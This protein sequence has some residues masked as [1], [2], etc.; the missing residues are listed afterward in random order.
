MFHMVIN[1]G[2]TSANTLE[3]LRLLPMY[4]SRGL[5]AQVLQGAFV[6]INERSWWKSNMPMHSI[7]TGKIATDGSLKDGIAGWGLTCSKVAI[8]ATVEG[9]QGID[10]AEACAL[11][12][13]VYVQVFN[14]T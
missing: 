4:L 3:A 14:A 12:A 9:K 2:F 1:A 8:F 7:D 11:L 13:A 10:I 6:E 5:K